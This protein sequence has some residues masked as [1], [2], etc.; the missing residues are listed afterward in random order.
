MQIQ[1]S[2][3]YLMDIHLHKTTIILHASYLEPFRKGNNATFLS[4]V[5]SPCTLPSSYLI[6]LI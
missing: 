3:L 2:E 6:S 1:I 4:V 5:F